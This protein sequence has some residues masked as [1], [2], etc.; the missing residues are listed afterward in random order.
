LEQAQEYL[1]FYVNKMVPAVTS[2]KLWIPAVCHHEPMISS[3]I[4]NTEGELRITA[5]TEAFVSTLYKVEE[6]AVDAQM[7]TD[8]G[9]QE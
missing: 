5:S 6:V 4:P 7:G 8:K 2:C 1:D 3:K 9:E